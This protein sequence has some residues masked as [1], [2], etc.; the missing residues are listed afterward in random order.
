M[1]ISIFR[2]T[3]LIALALSWSCATLAEETLMIEIQ[4]DDFNLQE[5][6][7]S[8]LAVGESEIIY[9]ESGKEL[10]MTR[11]E[12]GM[13]VLV[14]GEKIGPDPHLAKAECNVEVIVESDCENCEVELHKMLVLAQADGDDMGC[15]HEN[16][17][18]EKAWVSE[19]GQQHVFKHI[20][21]HSDGDTSTHDGEVRMIMIH[22]EVKETSEEG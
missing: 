13:E 5:T 9:T 1:T 2:N 8:H 16:V 3:I 14:D 21:S 18:I 6:N 11:T 12:H 10:T 19:D 22:K 20:N 4:G 7:L 17:D 15:M